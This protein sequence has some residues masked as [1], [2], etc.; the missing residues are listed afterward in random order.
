MT[1]ENAR[2]SGDDLRASMFVVG[3]SERNSEKIVRAQQKLRIE[4]DSYQAQKLQLIQKIKSLEIL[5]AKQ[6]QIDIIKSRRK[7]QAELDEF[8]AQRHRG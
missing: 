2:V 4:L 5:E 1:E 7:S 6:R 3:N 8:V